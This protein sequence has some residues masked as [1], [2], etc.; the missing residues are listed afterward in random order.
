VATVG[1]RCPHRRARHRLDTAGDNDVVVPGDHAGSREVDG[2]LTRAT[3]PVHGH[4][5]H[6]FRPA[7]R[8]HRG[9]TDIECLLPGL[10]D[11]APDHVVDDLGVDAG[12]LCQTVEHLRR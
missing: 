6:A 2:L 9:A 11:A 4:A 8:Q 12:T 5:G 10:H 1:E 7:R 3:L